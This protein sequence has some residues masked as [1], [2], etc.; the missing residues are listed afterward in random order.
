MENYKKLAYIKDFGDSE[1]Y[2]TLADVPT[3]ESGTYTW[4]GI[5]HAREDHDENIG[6]TS[7]IP[8]VEVL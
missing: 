4:V 8:L 7:Y 2:I 1:Q 3:Q 5:Q 6:Y